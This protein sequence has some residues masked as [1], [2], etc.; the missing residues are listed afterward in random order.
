MN[1]TQ[2][3]TYSIYSNTEQHCATDTHDIIQLI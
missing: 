2:Q 1:A 3:L